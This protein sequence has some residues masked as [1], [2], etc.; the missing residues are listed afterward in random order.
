MKDHNS[1]EVIWTI[2]LKVKTL[3][4]DQLC[5]SQFLLNFNGQLNIKTLHETLAEK[6][7]QTDDEDLY[8]DVLNEDVLT[9]D[10]L[11]EDVLIEDV[12]TGDVL[13]EDA[14]IDVHD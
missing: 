7:L 14:L 10:V 5:G 12:L 6:L 8:S 13:T 1:L 2:R 3:L 11:P 9:E 4:A